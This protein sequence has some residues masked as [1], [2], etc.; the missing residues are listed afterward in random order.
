MG[1]RYNDE[2]DD[3]YEDEYAGSTL[4]VEILDAI[5]SRDIGIVS[6]KEK[7]A[8]KRAEEE[9]RR[10]RQ[11]QKMT[12]GKAARIIA[13]TAAAAASI[14]FAY[15]SVPGSTIYPE[16]TISDRALMSPVEVAKIEAEEEKERQAK[17]FT[18]EAAALAA[19]SET[20]DYYKFL[21]NGHYTSTA[22]TDVVSFNF[23]D[24][25]KTYTGYTSAS[26]G[27]VGRYEIENDNGRPYLKVTTDSALDRYEIQI[28]GGDSDILLISSSGEIFSLDNL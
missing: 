9:K 16:N 13:Y 4:D 26:A 21:L 5:D 1:F 7:R 11:E 14:F 27:D 19:G 20:L 6:R 3:G 25:G 10:R 8:R 18:P 12:A 23:A 22:G 15:T 2:Y 24:D 17:A 28:N